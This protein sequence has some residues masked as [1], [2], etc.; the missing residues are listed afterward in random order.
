MKT[1]RPVL[2]GMLLCGSFGLAMAGD[3]KPHSAL[4]GHPNFITAE[5]DLMA[6]SKSISKSQEANECVFRVEGGH[7]AK[8][9]EAIEAAEKQVWEAAE[10]AN[11]HDNDCKEWEK[12]NKGAK[13]PKRSPTEPKLKGHPN[14]KGHTNMIAAEK[15]LIG[16]YEA[17]ERSQEANECVYGV[18]GGHGQKAKEAIDA[19]FKQVTESAE[20]VNTHDN[21]CKEKAAV[22]KDKKE[23]AKDK[24]DIANDKKDL[25]ND[26][27]QLKK[28]EKK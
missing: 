25:S 7:G 19:A 5:K 20:W 26:Q 22:A 28:D 2:F 4:K 16:A 18:E 9:K 1:F 17:V 23:I 13:G 11:T 27:K 14:L 24:K 3:V 21:E 10:W 8:A 12:K 6:A 15:D